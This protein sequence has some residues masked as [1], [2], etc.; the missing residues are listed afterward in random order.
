MKNKQGSMMF[1]KT[2]TSQETPQPFEDSTQA[3]SNQLN[4]PKS[5]Y[6]KFLDNNL[7]SQTNL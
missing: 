1:A 2:P 6:S 4:R 3:M 7:N 5:N